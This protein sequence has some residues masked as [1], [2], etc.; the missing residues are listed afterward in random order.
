MYAIRSYYVIKDNELKEVS[1]NENSINCQ[2][3]ILAVGH[4]ARTT[5]EHLLEKDVY[6]ENKPFSIGARIEHS[7][8]DVNHSLYGKYA[9]NPYLPQGEYQLSHRQNDGRA[10][11]TFCMCPGVV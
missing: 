4:S 9:G 3:L 1:S 5:F 8:D 7:Q 2:A 6:I 10:V 11:Y